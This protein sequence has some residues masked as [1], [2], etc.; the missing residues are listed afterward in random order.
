VEERDKHV[1][2]ETP[3]LVLRQYTEADVDNLVELD[4]DPEVMRY[5]TGG[6]PTPRQKIAD[7][8]I[9]FHL[10]VYGRLDRLGHFAAESA[11]TGEFLGWFHFR[12]GRG[13]TARRQQRAGLLQGR[14]QRQVVEDGDGGD[15]VVGPGAGEPPEV[16][17]AEP[18]AA[19]VDR[20]RQAP[21]QLAQHPR[22]VEVVVAPRV[23]GIERVDPP[24]QPRTHQCHLRP[25]S[26]CAARATAV[27]SVAVPWARH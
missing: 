3:R 9:P 11:G 1:I 23:R 15:G 10:A 21:R 17:G 20:P 18:G 5:L 25:E 12:P 8:I 2:I 14:L 6:E 7:E 22:M 19:Q 16:P 4:S 13:S 26:N 27:N 24:H